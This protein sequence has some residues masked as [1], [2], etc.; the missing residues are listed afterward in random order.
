LC[1]NVT[2]P[3]ED[4]EGNAESGDTDGESAHIEDD[5]SGSDDDGE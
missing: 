5:D 3:L 1:C 4:W 2:L